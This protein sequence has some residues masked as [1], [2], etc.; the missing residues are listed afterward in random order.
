MLIDIIKYV[1]LFYF[2]SYVFASNKKGISMF[3]G[4]DAIQVFIRSYENLTIA[5]SR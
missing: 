4:A 2:L 3:S 5:D 1:L